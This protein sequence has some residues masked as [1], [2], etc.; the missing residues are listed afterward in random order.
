MVYYLY[1]MEIITSMSEPKNNKQIKKSYL[2]NP[3][4]VHIVLLTYISF[5]CTSCLRKVEKVCNTINIKDKTQKNT[6]TNFAL[7]TDV[8]PESWDIHCLDVIFRVH[9][10]G[11]LTL[12]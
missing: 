4:T 11:E 10:L 8:L 12:I 5:A 6:K 7:K 2:W 1:N 9:D 3:G